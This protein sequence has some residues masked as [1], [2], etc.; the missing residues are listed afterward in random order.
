MAVAYFLGHSHRRNY[1]GDRGRQVP[2]PNFWV[3][4]QQCIGPLQLFG[5]LKLSVCAC[6][7]RKRYIFLIILCISFHA[8]A[9]SL[10]HGMLHRSRCGIAKVICI[11]CRGPAL[12]C[13]L[14]DAL[15]EYADSAPAESAA[16]AHMQGFAKVI[17]HDNFLVSLKCAVAVS[18]HLENLNRAVQSS[19][20]S[21]ASMVT[22]M[23][24]TV[25]ALND[26][27]EDYIIQ[28]LF[29]EAVMLCRDSDVPFPE[30]PRQRR[31]PK[32]LCGTAPAHAW[33]TPEEYFRNQFFQVV[34]TAVTQ[35]KLKYDCSQ[36]C[37][38]TRN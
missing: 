18:N 17:G 8:S 37:T 1:H 32:R 20:N 14:L 33:T 13:I 35:L 36:D 15:Q 34:D 28:A 12:K 2:L 26:L 9:R 4:D 24:M 16:K 19:S 23:K 22:A 10:W 38:R 29:E 5:Q 30:L 31:P 27:R 3:G 21:V 11:L 6:N 25:G 7:M